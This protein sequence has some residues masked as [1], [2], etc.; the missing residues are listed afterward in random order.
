MPSIIFYENQHPSGGKTF[1]IYRKSF[2][3]F[4]V[5]TV[6]TQALEVL[7][8]AP[9]PE[10]Q[11]LTENERK[12]LAEREESTLRELRL[13]LRDVLSRLANER[14]FRQFLRPVDSEEVSVWLEIKTLLINI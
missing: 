13:F 14:K 7:P 4:L 5:F 6:A 2:G 8:I 10:P 9:P 3:C 11:K 1:A 12:K